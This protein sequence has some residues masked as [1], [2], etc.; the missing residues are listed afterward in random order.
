MKLYSIPMDITVFLVRQSKE[1][2]HAANSNARGADSGEP[3][4]RL[5]CTRVCARCTRWRFECT[6]VHVRMH[7]GVCS[8]AARVLLEC[9]EGVDSNAERMCI[10]C[11]KV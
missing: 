1:L 6:R 4:F 11:T 3:W 7:G 5:E 2:D 9:S 8:N 10:K